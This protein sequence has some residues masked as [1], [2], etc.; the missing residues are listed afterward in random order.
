MFFYGL[1][2]CVG[3]IACN[4]AIKRV[5]MKFLLWPKPIIF[6]GRI[7]LFALPFGLL[8]G[9]INENYIS[10]TNIAY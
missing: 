7:C 1:L 6:V 4:V 8:S 10:M 5:Y 2:S 3:G 9:K